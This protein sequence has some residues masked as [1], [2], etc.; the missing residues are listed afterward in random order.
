MINIVVHYIGTLTAILALVIIY[1]LINERKKLKPKDFLVIMVI[2]LFALVNTLTNFTMSKV[3]VYYILY[4]ITLRLIYKD[5]LKK[6]FIGGLI[7]YAIVLF[8][9]IICARFIHLVAITNA[10]ELLEVPL[11]KLL[12]STLTIFVSLAFVYI[13]KIHKFLRKIID[14]LV[15][16]DFIIVMI[17]IGLVILSL[18]FITFKNALNFTS[19]TYFILNIILFIIIIF[20]F[21]INVMTLHKTNKLEEREEILLNFMK[22]NEYLIDKDRINKHELLNDLLVLK[23]F[24]DKNS[25]ECVE[26]LDTLIENH[27]S[28]NSNMVK[29]IYKLPTGLKCVIYYKMHQMEQE[30]IKLVTNISSNTISKLDKIGGKIFT[31]ICKVLGILLDNAIEASK[32]CDKKIISVDIYDKENVIFIEII[33]TADVKNINLK[34]INE[35]NY[36]SKGVNRG[37]GLY[38]VKRIINNSSNF[39]LE[40]KIENQTFVSIFKIKN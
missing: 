25:N 10:E 11:Y 18:S 7:C 40:Q 24:K 35:K 20:A 37:Y 5:E 9:E 31:K 34:K 38:I 12:I 13:E 26:W 22:K 32:I 36:S 8:A 2:S 29:N 16:R 3:L 33:N 23:S 30:E 19:L 39:E 4:I 27:K 6:L 15:S 17:L 28:G 21:F 14:I 1:N